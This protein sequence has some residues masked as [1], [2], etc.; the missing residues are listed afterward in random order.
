MTQPPFAHLAV[1]DISVDGDGRVSITNPWIA[2]RLHAA[3]AIKRPARDEPSNG[4]CNGC[5]AVRGCGPS[6]NSSC[7]VNSLNTCSGRE[8]AEHGRK[9]E[10]Q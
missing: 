10:L 3:A 8:I 7:P 9:G 2:G 4:N 5:N 6:T 1:Q